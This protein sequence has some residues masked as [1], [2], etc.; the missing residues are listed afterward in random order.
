MPDEQ[1][2]GAAQVATRSRV[3]VLLDRVFHRKVFSERLLLSLL[4][5]LAFFLPLFFIPGQSIAPE[6][7]KMILLEILVLLATFVWAAGRLRDGHVDVPKSMLLLVSALLVVQFVVA[8]I[9]SPTPFASFVGSGYD[10]GTVSSFVVLFL[11]MFLGSVIF[12]NRDRVLLLYGAFLGSTVVIM[13]YHL[14]RQFFGANFLDFGVFTN[15]VATPVGRWNDLASLV[16]AMMLL[17]LTT[18]YF[19]PNNKTLRIPAIVLFVV[20]LLF[21]LSINFTALWLI[22]IVLCGMLVALSIYEGEREHT[23]K[24]L[25]AKEAGTHHA[26]KPIY[27]RVSGHLP[28]GATIL[29]ICAVLYGSGL[30]NV[31]WG[32]SGS[33]ISKMVGNT[34]HSAPY[35]EVVLT[36]QFTFDI[37]KSTIK[38]SPFF[39]TGPNRFSSAYLKYK[40]S[41]VNR[42]PFWDTTFDFGLGRIPTYFGTTGI[43]GVILWLFFIIFL[44]VKGR[45]VFALLA[46]DRIAAYIGFSLFLLSLYFWSMAFFYLPNIAIFAMAFLFTG[47]LIAFLSGEGVIKSYHV[48]FDGGR[49]SIILTPV[50]IMILVGVIAGGVLLYRQVASLD[51]FG[52]AQVSA[53]ANNIAETERYLLRANGFVERDVY[54]RAL[55][56]VALAK[57]QDL[58]KQKL[59]QE[60]VAAKAKVLIDDAR[61]NAER[62]IKLDPTNFENYLQYGGVFDTLGSL[63]IQNTAPLARD[64]YL[65]ALRLNPKSPRVLFMLSHLEFAAGDR[66]KA[67]DYLYKTLAERPNFP[68]ALSFL[69]QLEMQD[70]NPDAAITALRSGIEAEP[71]SFLLRFALGYLYYLGNDLPNAVSE[72]EAAVSLNPSYADAKY[73]LGLS[74]SRLGRNADA[75]E[76]F[77]GVQALNPDNKD[78]AA[79]ISNLK[80]GRDPFAGSAPAPAKR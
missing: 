3:K 73:F 50:A 69:V 17:V 41:V 67:K 20:G 66:V 28:L 58:A 34:L 27:H 15:A 39:G 54:R 26:H 29:L 42:T 11:L 35:S 5:G 65:Q 7:A 60:E 10:L 49:S 38:D 72:F 51:A 63:G 21:L 78:V 8:A 68:E 59:S 46:K 77:K 6:F 48:N 23:K 1:Q 2:H 40:M 57:L 31:T 56:N 25:Q 61:T 53:G 18:R 45:K 76:Q 74:Y 62:A 13:L 9:A 22:L 32:S 37:V 14:L 33:T 64:N 80:A 24:S 55:S 43:V 47:T 12:S 36:P 52:A 71:S 79:I 16:G 4:L 44:F 70:K 75:I 19:F 30:S